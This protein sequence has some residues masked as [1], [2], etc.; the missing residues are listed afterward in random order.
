MHVHA[1]TVA[2]PLLS[3]LTS[4]PAPLRV[5][6]V[7]R[8]VCNLLLASG[9]VLALV[10]PALGEGP[11]HVVL[12]EPVPFEAVCAKSAPGTAT[13][14]QVV[15]GELQVYLGAAQVW[16]PTPRWSESREVLVRGKAI[17]APLLA[18]APPDALVA[19]VNERVQEAL[20]AWRQRGG[21]AAGM[22]HL[23]RALAGL[24][25][26]LTP[27][28]DDVLLGLLAAWHA[29]RAAACMPDATPPGPVV[30]QVAQGRTTRLSAAWLRHAAAGRF[31]A[32][33][34][35]LARALAEQNPAEVA[36]AGEGI[37]HTGASSGYYGLWGF[38]AGLE[39]F[40]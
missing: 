30:V 18:G 3:F 5:L 27:A 8:H 21:C 16:D 34:H 33:W 7:H 39:G 26:G 1:Q 31:A 23:A 35:R 32:A 11:F 24:G 19:A 38:V 6:S 22:V 25:P 4:V 13:G 37:M 20:A 29:C 10:H 12:A 15:V 9:E 36:R 17:L 40:L 28:G 2:R 14:E